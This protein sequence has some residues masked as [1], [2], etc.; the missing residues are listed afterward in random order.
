M[1]EYT[2]QELQGSAPNEIVPLRTGP[3]HS[4]VIKCAIGMLPALG[5]VDLGVVT[6]LSAQNSMHSRQ[7]TK[8]PRPSEAKKTNANGQ[9]SYV[10]DFPPNTFRRVMSRIALLLLGLV[11][12]ANAQQWYGSVSYTG[13]AYVFAAPEAWKSSRHES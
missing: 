9:I 8:T 1:S 4:C 13:S 12:V 3:A 5:K 2:P 10:E 6:L 11:A 7:N